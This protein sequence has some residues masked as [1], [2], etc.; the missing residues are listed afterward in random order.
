[1]TMESLATELADLRARVAQLEAA[2][3]P[4]KRPP[5]AI[6]W[7]PPRPKVEF[8]ADRT[9]VATRHAP[10]PSAYPEPQP[11]TNAS[12][13]TTREAYERELKR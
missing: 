6:Y 3:D 12:D 10:Y 13:S 5:S 4:P 8:F 9:R 1:M 11:Q 2:I 7:E